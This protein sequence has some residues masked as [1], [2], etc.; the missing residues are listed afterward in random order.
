MSRRRYSMG[1]E[2]LE[3][4][5]ALAGDVSAALEGS[6]LVVRGD[7]QAN[8]LAVTQNSA[9][10]V[11][12]Q[13]LNGT[14][15]NGLASL[16][17]PN[18]QLNSADVRMEGGDDQL[19]VTEL[20]TTTDLN[21]DLG[22]GDDSASVVANVGGNLTIKGEAG[23][24]SVL[25]RE[26]AVGLDLNVEMGTGTASVDVQN[27]T[28]AE[29][30]TLITDVLNDTVVADNLQ[31]GGDLNVET[32]EGSD[33]VQVSRITAKSFTSVT[34]EG[35]DI[36]AAIDVTVSQDVNVETGT[37]DDRVTLTHVA[38]GNSVKVN[39]D[40]GDDYVVATVVSAAVDANFV[41][42]DGFDTLNNN[43]I[44]AGAVLELKEFEAFVDD[45]GDF[46]GNGVLDAADIDLL[47]LE[48]RAG[49]NDPLFDLNGDAQVNEDDRVFWI[50]DLKRTSLGDA[51]LNGEFNSS[52]LVLALAGGQY[53]DGVERN[54]TWESGDWNGDG[55]FTSADLIVALA[56]GAYERPTPVM[57]TA[58]SMAVDALF[59]DRR[60]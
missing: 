45:L 32:K 41:G 35:T 3:D 43:G 39:T 38:A 29:N 47:S 15:V 60:A 14:T 57:T 34:D 10:D 19:T 31:M 7:D 56:A 16:T 36:V 52:D 46:S 33:D 21:I 24:D 40:T 26:T 48:V 20:G 27:S 37:N 44:T 59:S 9:G 5:V 25:V 58:M 49:S 8:E 12:V 53:E 17:L 23:N 2:G 28:V 1:T 54:S 11:I 4:R 50:R 18:P 55:D 30:T 51:D 42:G 13:G 22:T 6:L